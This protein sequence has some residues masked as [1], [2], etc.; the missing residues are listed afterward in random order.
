MLRSRSA[1]FVM[2]EAEGFDEYLFLSEPG[3]PSSPLPEDSVLDAVLAE[4][5]GAATVE[6]LR[7][8]A[9][10]L[11]GGDVE[12]SSAELSPEEKARLEALGY[13]D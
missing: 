4:E 8:R 11:L 12:R 1:L 9:E 10:V 13:L 6:A 7:A 2:R 3:P 5:G